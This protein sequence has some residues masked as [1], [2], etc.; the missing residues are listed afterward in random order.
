MTLRDFI[1]GTCEGIGFAIG[2]AGILACVVF[3]IEAL[4]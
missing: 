1:E 3:A 4:G 2:L